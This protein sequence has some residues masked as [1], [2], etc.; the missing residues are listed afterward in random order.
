MNHK[1]ISV[2]LKELREEQKYKPAE[3][4]EL[5]GVEETTVLNWEFGVSEPTI[6][7]SLLLSKLYNIDLNDMFLEFDE[8]TMVPNTSV[9]AFQRVARQNR[10]INR[11][12][13]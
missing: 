1:K 11:W 12:Y 13:N 7:E 8:M 9:T 5:L 4:A 3:L 10:Y 6:S 2:I